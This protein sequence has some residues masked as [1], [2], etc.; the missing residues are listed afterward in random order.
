M[1]Y[2]RWFLSININ[3]PTLKLDCIAFIFPLLV[4]LEPLMLA[5]IPE[6]ATNV[7]VADIKCFSEK[8]KGA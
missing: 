1:V 6:G 7:F 4:V 5:K 8:E 2:F 3:K